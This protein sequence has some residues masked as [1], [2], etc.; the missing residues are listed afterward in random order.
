MERNRNL[1]GTPKRSA[2]GLNQNGIDNFGLNP[3]KNPQ[4]SASGSS[5]VQS[6]GPR[7][8]LWTDRSCFGFNAEKPYFLGF[9]LGL[10]EG[11]SGSKTRALLPHQFT[12]RSFRLT[13]GPTKGGPEAHRNPFSELFHLESL[14]ACLNHSRYTHYQNHRTI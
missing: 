6:K 12:V 1:T 4:N 9:I 3:L 5:S 13:F 11:A 8:Q 10:I 7:A 2:K 14:I